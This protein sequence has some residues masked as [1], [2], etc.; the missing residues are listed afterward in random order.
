MLV[1]YYRSKCAF[2][3]LETFGWGMFYSLKNVF[4]VESRYKFMV[5]FAQFVHWKPY[6]LSNVS[7]KTEKK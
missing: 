7:M 4:L 3:D 1:I 2:G 5:Y 6:K